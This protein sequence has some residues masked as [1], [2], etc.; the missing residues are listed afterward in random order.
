MNYG[1]VFIVMATSLL[2]C[3]PKPFEK[4]TCREID[5]MMEADQLYRGDH[6]TSA[7]FTVADSLA[8]AKYG[9]KMIPDDVGEFMKEAYDITQA[10][11]A[12]D[13]IDVEFADSLWA[14]QDAIDDQNVERLL[15]I[16][17][18]STQ[19]ELDA[20]ECLRKQSLLPFVH[21]DEK[22]AIQVRQC[23]DRHKAYL[24]YNRYR[25]IRWHLDG[26]DKNITEEEFEKM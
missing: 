16:F 11:P 18:Q 10:R 15:E 21:S 1:I 13:F 2:A 17:E 20:L 12:S 22:Y 3:K 19:E 25:H 26:R 23:I 6:R 14:L 7:F 9:D 4:P 24:G 5:T 8:R